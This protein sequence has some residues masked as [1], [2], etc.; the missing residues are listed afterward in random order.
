MSERRL[1]RR[2]SDLLGGPQGRDTETGPEG[3]AAEIP[4]VLIDPNP[5]QPRTRFDPEKLEELK[6]S[7]RATGVL[8]PILVRPAGER[9]QVVAGERRLRAAKEVLLERIPAIVR[10]VGD[11]ELLE[12]A[13]VEN[14]QRA[15]LNP[16]EKAKAYRRLMQE[17][18]LTQEEV[19]ERVG[20]SRSSVA[21]FCRLLELPKDIQDYVSR[22]TISMGHARALLSSPD[23]TA[24]RRLA[25]RIVKD[26]L[27]VRETERLAALGETGKRKPLTKKSPQVMR[28][29]DRLK[30]HLGTR[31]R[32]YEGKKRSRIVVDFYGPEDF[33]RLM[34]IIGL[35]RED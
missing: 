13:L 9:Y 30:R 35:A 11:E 21:N 14:L 1:G 26:G 29:E 33:D 10:T 32:I 15:D 17:F 7:I 23:G 16:I 28:L 25:E 18:G 12:L 6:S 22:G 19:A 34:Q 20:Q 27:S 24:Q 4:V 2:L 3:R 5:L 31:V 8:Q